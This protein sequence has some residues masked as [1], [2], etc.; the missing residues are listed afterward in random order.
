MRLGVA[1]GLMLLAAAAARAA[2]QPQPA[3]VPRAGGASHAALLPPAPTAAVGSGDSTARHDRAVQYLV[4]GEAALA[5]GM[6]DTAR[7]A[8]EN[9]LY[10]DPALTDASVRLARLLT[11]DGQ[12]FFAQRVLERAL[13]YDP[14]NPELLHFSARRRPTPD[15]G[16]G[17]GDSVRH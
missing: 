13:H 3:A 1:L 8:W 12:G 7:V 6:R 4:R 15:S 5:A 9:A 16:F 2:A 17:V 14:R 11:E 10:E